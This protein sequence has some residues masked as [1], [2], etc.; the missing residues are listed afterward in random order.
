[1]DRQQALRRYLVG[2]LAIGWAR[3]MA[4]AL[5]ALGVAA[6]GGCEMSGGTPSATPSVAPTVASTAER[7]EPPPGPA[8]A[9]F[10]VTVDG[11]A[12]DWK[13]STHAPGEST[14][15]A[16]GI[17]FVDIETG[18]GERWWASGEPVPT[19]YLPSPTG[20]QVSQ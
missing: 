17:L 2:L 3:P 19:E 5:A 13:T 8:P 11:R 16:H 20:R 7:T 15:F 9:D 10:A 12:T 1:M 14:D 4:F 6:A 18:A